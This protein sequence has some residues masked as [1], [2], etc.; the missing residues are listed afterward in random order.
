MGKACE[1]FWRGRG[2]RDWRELFFFSVYFSMFSLCVGR[3]E[4][5]YSVCES[6][7]GGGKMRLPGENEI[8]LK[9][10]ERERE[11]EP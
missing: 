11:R 8:E 1:K 7:I 10:I 4:S 3:R 5:V 2:K 9:F 6:E